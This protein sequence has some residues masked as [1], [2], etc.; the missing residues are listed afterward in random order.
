MCLHG[1]II[2]EFDSYVLIPLQTDNTQNTQTII[3][4][5]NAITIARDDFNQIISDMTDKLERAKIHVR[6]KWPSTTDAGKLVGLNFS[7][8]A[9]GQFD[10]DKIADAFADIT[11]S[12]GVFIVDDYFLTLDYRHG[13]EMTLECALLDNVNVVD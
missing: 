2:V 1:K 6:D 3:S 13:T 12:F 4:M 7:V 11:G 9:I 10:I 8:L 5:T